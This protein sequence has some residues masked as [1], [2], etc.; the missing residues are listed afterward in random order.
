M[1]GAARRGDAYPPR[2]KGAESDE[3]RRDETRRDD[4][5]RRGSRTA[6]LNAVPSDRQHRLLRRI[7]GSFLLRSFKLR[8]ARISL[9]FSLFYSLF[10]SHAFSSFSPFLPLFSLLRCISV[11]WPRQPR[12]NDGGKVIAGGKRGT[13]AANGISLA[14][15]RRPRVSRVAD[16]YV[17]ERPARLLARSLARSL[18][19]CTSSLLVARPKRGGSLPP[20][21]MRGSLYGACVQSIFFLPLPMYICICLFIYP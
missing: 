11:A 14:C 19:V 10:F 3:R 2:R 21:W 18:R 9:S 17:C 5:G 20:T 6:A 15:I 12:Y 8:H 4:E 1:H 13:R 7:L 16:V